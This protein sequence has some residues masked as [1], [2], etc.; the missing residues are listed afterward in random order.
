MFYSTSFSDFYV[1][2]LKGA[3]VDARDYSG[4]RPKDYLK[5]NAMPSVKSEFT[6]KYNFFSIHDSHRF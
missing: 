4:K 6:T 1:R 5:R 3:N 2:F